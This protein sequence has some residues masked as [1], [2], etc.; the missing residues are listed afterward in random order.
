MAVSCCCCFSLWPPHFNLTCTSHLHHKGGGWRGVGERGEGPSSCGCWE[1]L[2]P[3][4]LTPVSPAIFTD[5]FSVGFSPCMFYEIIIAYPF[6]FFPTN[7]FWW[8]RS[9]CCLILLCRPLEDSLQ[10]SD[11]QSTVDWGDCWIRTQDC[12]FTIWCHYQ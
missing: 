6:F 7:C 10:G 2:S 9:P 4:G 11:W 8:N 1:V 12:S 3:G 5:H